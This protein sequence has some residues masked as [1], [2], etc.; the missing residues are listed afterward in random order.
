VPRSDVEDVIDSRQMG[1]VNALLPHELRRRSRERSIERSR[2]RS[3]ERSSP[4]DP[5]SRE[6]AGE[7]P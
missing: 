1:A 7:R 2:E 5:A 3:P 4:L 6:T